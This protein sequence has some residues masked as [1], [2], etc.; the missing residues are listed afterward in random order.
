MT[1]PFDDHE[2]AELRRALGA[3]EEQAPEAPELGRVS[4]R[5]DRSRR[6]LL[7]AAGAAAL[8]LTVLLPV[9]LW[10]RGGEDPS[11]ESSTS[12]TAAGTTSALEGTV[13]ISIPATSPTAS[14]V[15]APEAGY[16]IPVC[17]AV[18]RVSAPADAY[19]DTPIYVANEMP[20]SE[21]KAWARAQPGFEGIW[22]DRDHNGWITVAFSRDADVRLADL[23]REFP[24]VGV[25]AV[26][27]DW[28]M[29]DLRALQSR[30]SSD[31]GPLLDSLATWI[32]EDKGVV[33][34][35]V[36]VLTDDIRSDVEARFGDEP[37]CLDGRDPAT[38]PAPGPQPPSGDGW[39]L[40]I[41][42]SGVG[43]PYRTGIATDLEGLAALWATIGL[44]GPLPEVDF[45]SEVVVW[46]G[47]VFSGSC[48]G[49]RLD[50]VVVDGS[51]L[52]ALIVLL[53]A[54]MFCTAD[55]NP[56][57]YVVAVE[58]SKLPAGPFI[59]QLSAGG[60]PP[61]APEERTV[62]DADLSQPGAVATAGQ[63][64]SDPNL[65][66]PFVVKTGDIIE[67]G[68]PVPYD[69][70]VHCGI[71]W[72]GELNRFNWRTTDAMPTE[73]EALVGETETIRVELLLRTEPVPVIEATA[74]DV[75][76]TYSPTNDPDP[77]CD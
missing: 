66:Q 22:I 32:S 28:T 1:T 57:A 34:I 31:L 60:P 49:I 18:P 16:S 43:R 70:N 55:A 76:I 29:A 19:A 6:P 54:P 42:E 2:L 15:S 68:F 23:E 14:L 40:L 3:M 77:G 10:L 27:V 73:W 25:V 38:M 62:V 7:V 47:A 48:P 64:G 45:E 35:D 20:T 50:D 11:G 59:I 71:E 44:D 51:I 17:D 8:T 13:P 65:P 41:D 39:R 75:T 53:D 46:F 61:G 9:G 37:V 30:V 63:I 5:V 74:G 36:G 72:L 67:P 4:Q 21:V 33:G 52:H 58:R 12:V 56:R 26:A 24:G 69:L